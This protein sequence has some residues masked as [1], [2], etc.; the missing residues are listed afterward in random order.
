[1]DHTVSKENFEAKVPKEGVRLD[2]RTV[3][4]ALLTQSKKA[5]ASNWPAD[6][7]KAGMVRATRV[8]LGHAY[9]LLMK[10]G[11]KDIDGK[12][13]TKDGYYYG[14]WRG[15]QGGRAEGMDRSGA[16]IP[17]AVGFAPSRWGQRRFEAGA[18]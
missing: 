1:M 3:A 13:L 6:F 16:T 15:L 10:V 7:D 11:D 17:G 4:I 12:V 18:D 9:K 14:W 5:L 8:P 2:D